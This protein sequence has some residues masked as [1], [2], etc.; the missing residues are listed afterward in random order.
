M[1]RSRQRFV[2]TVWR[3]NPPRGVLWTSVPSVEEGRWSGQESHSLVPWRRRQSQKTKLSKTARIT[4]PLLFHQ[5]VVRLPE[6]LLKP[7]SRYLLV[8]AYRGATQVLEGPLMT[9]P[10]R[11]TVI[12]LTAW[13]VA[14]PCFLFGRDE[15]RRS[16]SLVVLPSTEACIPGTAG[17]AT[18]KNVED[19]GP[20]VSVA[21]MLFSQKA[22]RAYEHAEKAL[23]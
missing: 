12:S 6:I 14:S 16:I 17:L 4:A 15:P 10:V 8:C 19:A 5:M 11:I 20:T 23:A 3:S 7:D 18:R 13:L 1:I 9:T 2:C 22:R 21:S